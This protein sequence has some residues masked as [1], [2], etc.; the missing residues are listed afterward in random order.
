[1]QYKTGIQRPQ[2]KEAQ[3]ERDAEHQRLV[4]QHQPVP[5]HERPTEPMIRRPAPRCDSAASS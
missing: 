5:P 1:M 2:I 4:E 3:E